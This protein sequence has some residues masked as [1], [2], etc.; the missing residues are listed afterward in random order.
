MAAA[1]ND[2]L[3]LMRA[4]SALTV[5]IAAVFFFLP[6][7]A[8]AWF[9][10]P[11]IPPPQGATVDH[12]WLTFQQNMVRSGLPRFAV[13]LFTVIGSAALL[14]LCLSPLDLTCGEALRLDIAPFPLSHPNDRATHKLGTSPC[15]DT[16]SGTVS[17]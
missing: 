12:L 16:W 10:P 1:W 17:I 5:T 8:F 13:A 9:G 7:L 2:S 15:S 4:Y 14:R 3:Q 6:A 11:P